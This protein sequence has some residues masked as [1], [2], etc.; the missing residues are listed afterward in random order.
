MAFLNSFL[1]CRLFVGSVLSGVYSMLVYAVAFVIELWWIIEA[2]VK[3]PVPSYILAAG[4]FFTL[5]MSFALLAG[6]GLKRS[7]YLLGWLFVVILFYFP[8]C[9]LVLFMSLYY[10][11][12]DTYYGLTEFVFYICRAVINV[13]CIVCVQSQ[14]S[15]WQE[16]KDVMRRLENLNV[17]PKSNYNSVSLLSDQGSGISKQ[18]G[19]SNNGHTSGTLERFRSGQVHDSELHFNGI[20]NGGVMNLSRNPSNSSN[21]YTKRQN[22]FT[23][24]GIPANGVSN[25]DKSVFLGRPIPPPPPPGSAAFFRSEFDAASFSDFM[26]SRPRAHARSLSDFGY[27][28]QRQ[29]MTDSASD[30]PN[31]HSY[32]NSGF[33]ANDQDSIRD[34]RNGFSS[35]NSSIGY[36]TQSLERSK[37]R[38]TPSQRRARSLEDI[39]LQITDD[40]TLRKLPEDPFQ[41][42]GRPGSRMPDDVQSS[43]T[44]SIR[45][46]AL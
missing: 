39:T 22:G 28:L 5:V 46:I 9:G 25:S 19:I 1:C 17:V 29:V 38:R 8:E 20:P 16:E 2:E 34:Y 30:M 45:D 11:G 12:L 43:S 3:L 42:L 4:Y 14:Y 24:F 40:V 26:T 13:L 6:L 44:D 32:V 23:T 27:A 41:Y 35:A 7:K 33:F 37:Y 21:L 18:N 36:S 15:S 31:Y 10:W